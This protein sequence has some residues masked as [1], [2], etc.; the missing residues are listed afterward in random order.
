MRSATFITIVG[1]SGPG[2]AIASFN[3]YRRSGASGPQLG[4]APVSVPVGRTS[5]R[6]NAWRIARDHHRSD[7]AHSGCV[8]LTNDVTRHEVVNDAPVGSPERLKDE[9][10]CRT[11]AVARSPKSA[12]DL[13]GLARIELAT[14]A[15]SV[16]RSNQ[17]SYS[18][19]N[20]CTTLHQGPGMA[21]GGSHAAGLRVPVGRW[22][23]PPRP[24]P[25]PPVPPRPPRLPRQGSSPGRRWRPCPVT[26]SPAP[27]CGSP[28]PSW[29]SGGARP[30][31]RP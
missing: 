20:R 16:L 24:P 6:R 7:D 31:G 12:S 11:L 1:L 26:R 21:E 5:G 14:S 8:S 3:R 23:S 9:D 15:L 22:V 27:R 13:V 18:P 4:V 28:P 25:R 29:R 17:L 10:L 19:V 30:P 2:S